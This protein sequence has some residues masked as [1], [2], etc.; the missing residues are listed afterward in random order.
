M[1]FYDTESNGDLK[2]KKIF[3]LFVFVLFLFGCSKTDK[4]VTLQLFYS[5]Q[6]IALQLNQMT[7]IFHEKNP[8]ITIEV[9]CVPY[10]TKSILDPRFKAGNPPDLMMLQPYWILDNYVKSGYLVDL[11]REK[12][13]ANIFNSAKESV[14][15]NGNIYALPL[16]YTGI[17]VIY[18]KDIFNKQ[19]ITIPKTYSK[20][21]ES[22]VILKNNNITPFSVCIKDSSSLGYLFSIVH[23]STFVNKDE[24]NDW[25][26]SM[27]EGKGSFNT[28]KMEEIFKFFDYYKNNGGNKA[29]DMTYNDQTSS[30]ASG[31]SAMMIQ[32]INSYQVSKSINSK[33]NAGF[34]PLNLTDDESGSKLYSGINSV[35]VISAKSTPEKI[36]ASKKFLSFVASSEGIKILVEKCKFVPA[37]KHVSVLSLDFPYRDLY[38]YIESGD[39]LQ[40]RFQLWPQEVFESSKIFLQEYYSGKKSSKE[41]L[42]SLDEKWK[43]VIK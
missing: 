14:S 22:I 39:T 35:F 7:S 16:S 18:N 42:I 30:F 32:E 43:S 9:E 36:D 21:K 5:R 33:L 27:N 34:F 4:K 31:K 11:K 20:L 26:N 13:M 37:F 17:G 19:N 40:W 23:N 24:F 10:D 15:Y 41:V 25:I 12:Y 3:M 1:K 28:Q 29:L 2:M 8:N 38:K 6:D